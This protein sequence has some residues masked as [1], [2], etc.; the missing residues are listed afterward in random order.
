MIQ[1]HEL[2]IVTNVSI[3]ILERKRTELDTIAL[4]KLVVKLHPMQTKS[5]QESRET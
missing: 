2:K 5:V 1:I 4:V 3:D